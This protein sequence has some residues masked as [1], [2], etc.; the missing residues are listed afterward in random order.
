MKKK[1][2]LKLET[3]KLF[4]I[5]ALK[6]VFRGKNFIMYSISGDIIYFVLFDTQTISKTKGLT[7]SSSGTAHAVVSHRHFHETQSAM[8]YFV[9]LC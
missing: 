3:D 6:I 8:L 1:N 5:F 7:R 4:Y 2:F 9:P